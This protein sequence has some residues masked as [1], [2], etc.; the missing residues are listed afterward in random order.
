MGYKSPEQGRALQPQ[1][2]G[3]AVTWMKENDKGLC[4]SNRGGKNSYNV[5]TD[6]LAIISLAL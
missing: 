5:S 6:V 3:E 1:S 2:F 4:S